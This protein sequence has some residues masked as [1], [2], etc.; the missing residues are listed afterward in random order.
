MYFLSQQFFFTFVAIC[1]IKK[2]ENFFLFFVGNLCAIRF[3]IF[4]FKKKKKRP[5]NSKKNV[6]I[7]TYFNQKILILVLRISS[8]SN[9]E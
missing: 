3:T 5:K 9:I 8:K 7:M 6:V 1:K 2:F 4:Y